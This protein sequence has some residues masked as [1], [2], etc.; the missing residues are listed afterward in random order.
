MLYYARNRLEPEVRVTPK[1]CA[2]QHQSKDDVA[3]K[4]FSI[5]GWV[6]YTHSTQRHNRRKHGNE[7]I[8]DSSTARIYVILFSS[9][10]PPPYS[11]HNRPTMHKRKKQ[12]KKG[13]KMNAE[14]L[15]ASA[16]TT[17]IKKKLYITLRGDV[18]RAHDSRARGLFNVK[19]PLLCGLIPDKKRRQINFYS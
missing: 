1:S 10:P 14:K 13:K 8:S 9:S 6:V 18:V 5:L 16:R 12:K 15:S 4:E 11:A 17:A 19:T 7:V 2:L 3:S